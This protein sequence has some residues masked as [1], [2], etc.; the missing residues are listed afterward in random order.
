MGSQFFVSQKGHYT[1]RNGW[2]KNANAPKF[3][4][5]TV[6]PGET[7]VLPSVEVIPNTDK[8]SAQTAVL[9]YDDPKGIFV[10]GTLVDK[11]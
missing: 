4:A 6:K 3:L 1:S 2:D 10:L 9:K 8:T 7:L 5:F 11:N